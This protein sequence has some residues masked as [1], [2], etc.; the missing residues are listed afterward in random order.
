MLTVLTQIRPFVSANSEWTYGHPDGPQPLHLRY[1]PRLSEIAV[2][3]AAH[4]VAM[5]GRLS[6][7]ARGLASFSKVRTRRGSHI[8]I[9]MIWMS[10]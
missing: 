3:A 10:V 7:H 9:S 5:S 1:V 6:L 2:I 8:S 4:G